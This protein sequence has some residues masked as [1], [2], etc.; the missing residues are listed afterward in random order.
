MHGFLFLNDRFMYDHFLRR[1]LHF[2]EIFFKKRRKGRK[3]DLTAMGA[4]MRKGG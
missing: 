4:M 1:V 2:E 3:E